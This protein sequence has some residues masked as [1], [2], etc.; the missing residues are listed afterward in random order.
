MVATGKGEPV[1]IYETKT[2]V[3]ALPKE[4]VERFWELEGV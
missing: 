2:K 4:I 1:T 3:G